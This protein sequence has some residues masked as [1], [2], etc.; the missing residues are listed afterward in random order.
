MVTKLAK[1]G[2]TLKKTA[3]K[4]GVLYEAIPCRIE[5]SNPTK[6]TITDVKIEDALDEGLEYEREANAKI[7]NEKN[8]RSWSIPSLAAGERKVFDYLVIAKK[9]GAKRGITR[10]SASGV[11]PQEEVTPI[12]IV[13]A[14]L[15]MRLTPVPQATVG[16]PAE[17][18]LNIENKG[19]AT[20]NNIRL[21]LAHPA[22]DVEVKRATQGSKFFDDGVQWII[23]QLKAGESR[24]FKV[25][26][27][28]KT[29]GKR[30]F[31]ATA[32]ADRGAEV[33]DETQIDF[34][35]IPSLNWKTDGTPTSTEGK[36]VKYLVEVYNPGTANATNV[37][38]QV[39]LPPEVRLETANPPYDGGAS[40]G[41]LTFKP[42]HIPP[43]T[44][45]T[46]AINCLAVK[47][48]VAT[49]HFDL[50]ADHTKKSGTQH[51]EVSTIINARETLPA[52]LDRTTQTPKELPI[53]EKEPTKSEPIIAV[54]QE[55]KKEVEP[56]PN[57]TAAPKKEPEGIPP[58]DQ[59][60][61][62]GEKK[63]PEKKESPML[64]PIK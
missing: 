43:K 60:I 20:L 14:R 17:V 39:K 28:A 56:E 63:E 41:I 24:E 5:V 21:Y 30:K 36:D 11:S 42:I 7:D 25:Q 15:Q 54:K 31:T 47:K 23:T 19:T 38:L 33:Q 52:K 27:T 18:Q 55:P 22:K 49:F 29:P 64:T 34:E 13:E 6:L 45:A 37:T 2:L 9:T 4:E 32:K 8:Q 57:K 40:N 51:N 46:F 3:P 26:F 48:G 10:V 61:P 59:V 50:L 16:Q 35:G 53:K 1:P 62:L 58:L 44:K 12:N